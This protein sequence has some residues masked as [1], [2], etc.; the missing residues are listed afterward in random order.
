MRIAV[1]GPLVVDGH[2]G[3]IGPRDRVVLAALAVRPGE[4]HTPDRLAEALWGERPPASGRKVVQGCVARLRKALGPETIETL[5][6][7][8]RLLVS[9]DDLDTL[10]FEHLVGR[11]R[12]LLTVG[13][14]ER[15]SYTLD[16]AADLW[17]GEAFVDL[18]GWEP[19]RVEA[20]RLDELRLDSEEIGLDAALRAG[21]HLEVL[22]RAHDMVA[23]AP[24]RE[25][26]WGLL[27]L[28][29]YQAGRQA[30]ALRSLHQVRTVLANELGIDP[31][32]DLV[33]LEQAILQQDPSLLVE[34]AIPEPSGVCPYRGLMAYDVDDADTFFGRDADLATCLERLSAVGMLAVVG[35]SGSGKSS[36]VRAGV[37]ATYR[38]A[39]H[40]TVVV[41][42]GAHPMDALTGI[43]TRVRSH[44]SSW[45]SSRRSSHCARTPTNGPG[46]SPRWPH[47]PTGAGWWWR[48]APTEWERCRPTP[49]SRG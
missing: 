27:A 35:P 10:L 26:R 46:S 36:L 45:I 17:R 15:A 3:K 41:T 9:S 28:A 8:Y 18:D 32:P 30:E 34:P 22:A 44:C 13:E 49:T 5:P 7:G 12:E 16:Q 40:R 19:G 1:L 29:Q 20:G 23:A 42:P 25:R 47:T 38:R 31:S 6:R 4:V 11:G 33:A 24:V 14:P 39:G 37:A 2:V 43:P 48:C 21:H